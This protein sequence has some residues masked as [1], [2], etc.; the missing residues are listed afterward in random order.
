MPKRN[1]KLLLSYDGTQY[2]GWQR[3]GG[4]Q[5]SRSIQGL[6]ELRLSDLLEE[7][8]KIVGSGRTDAGVHAF[9]QVANFY[10][11][12]LHEVKDI[13]TEL[14]KELPEDIRVHAV[15]EV[16]KE[17]HSRLSA[18]KKIYRYYIDNEQREN[19]FARRYSYH[20]EER[21]DVLKMRAAAELLVGTH[22]FSSFTTITN[23]MQGE[24]KDTTR[25]LYYINIEESTQF[26]GT[27]DSLVIE[28]CGSGFLYNMVRILV[29]T[30]LEVGLGKRKLSDIERALQKRD[31][32]LAGFTAPANGL[33][34]TEVE[35]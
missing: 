27:T 5:K 8:I 31:R 11:D 12:T 33:F 4:E 15:S 24:E 13:Q 17:F 3:L 25:T 19:V 35:Y 1:I 29:G 6:L 20:V 18:K 28:F 23:D 16:E 10:T 14:N 22:D 2:L 9:S 32:Q 30:L 34:L 21:L 26:I 7:E